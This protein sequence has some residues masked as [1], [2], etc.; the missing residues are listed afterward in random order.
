MS[1][2]VAVTPA[3]PRAKIDS[4]IVTVTG[5]DVNDASAYDAGK[6]PTEPEGRYYLSFEKGGAEKGRSY[7]FGVDHTGKHVLNGYLF[8]EAGTFI[9]RLKKAVTDATVQSSSNITVQ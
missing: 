9:V 8:P 7:V 4:A 3:S 5:A 2:V 6:Y 1:V